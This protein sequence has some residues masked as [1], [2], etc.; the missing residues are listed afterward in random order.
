MKVKMNNPFFGMMDL[1]PA[2][3]TAKNGASCN[4]IPVLL[5]EGMS[6]TPQEATLAE[7]QFI[8]VS[9]RELDLL[10]KAGYL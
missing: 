7:Y 2:E 10:Q 3:I 1:Y 4:E 9:A 8:D 5:V 6:V